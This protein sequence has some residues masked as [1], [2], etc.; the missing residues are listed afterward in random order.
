MR[1]QVPLKHGMPVHGRSQVLLSSEPWAAGLLDIL[2][3]S[4]CVSSGGPPLLVLP[5]MASLALF[6]FTN[7]S[8]KHL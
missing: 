2:L 6:L 3:T 8:P 5:Q 1:S 4:K 7:F